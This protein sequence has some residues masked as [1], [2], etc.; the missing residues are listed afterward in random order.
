MTQLTTLNLGRNGLRA[1]PTEFTD[2]LESVPNVDITENPWSDWPKKWGKLFEKKSCSDSVLG[3]SVPD[4]LHF[5]YSVQ[6]FYYDAEKL[7]NIRG[8]FYYKQKLN[9]NDYCE[10][11]RRMMPPEKYAEIS[12]EHVKIMFFIVSQ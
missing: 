1:I 6:L 3:Y 11:L 7:W 10:D 5:L 8:A 9:L 4:V 2:I 12:M